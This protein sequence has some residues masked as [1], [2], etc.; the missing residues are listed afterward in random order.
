MSGLER[1]PCPSCSS[2]DCS[3][4]GCTFNSTAGKSDYTFEDNNDYLRV[5]YFGVHNHAAT[6]TRLCNSPVRRALVQQRSPELRHAWRYKDADS[7]DFVTQVGVPPQ[8]AIA[9]SYKLGTAQ[10]SNPF[11]NA[12]EVEQHLPKRQGHQ[13]WLR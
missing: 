5:L 13:S 6:G 2:S 4:F 10:Q 8:F 1:F 3:A 9:A 12:G 11:C 7:I